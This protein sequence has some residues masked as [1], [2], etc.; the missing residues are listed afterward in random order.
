MRRRQ[1]LK[2]AGAAGLA[3]ALDPGQAFA[4]EAKSP[5]ISLN[6]QRIR[7]EEGWDV[8]V[9]G[10]GPA[11]CTS[12]A[13]AAREGA[14]TLLIEGTGALGGMGTSGLLNAWCPFTDGKE[15]IYKGLAERVFLESLKGVP[16]AKT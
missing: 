5:S 13:A 14:R 9:V 2:Y 11:G 16:H 3:A 4:R 15:I 8:I 7:L 12:A 1:F 6:K 10:G